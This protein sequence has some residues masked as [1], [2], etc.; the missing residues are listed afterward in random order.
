MYI[1][2]KNRGAQTS[3]PKYTGCIQ[4]TPNPKRKKNT[5]LKN[6]KNNNPTLNFFLISKNSLKSVEGRNPSTQEVYKEA[7]N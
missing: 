5:N 6:Q 1:S 2:K 7:P 3:K 4:D